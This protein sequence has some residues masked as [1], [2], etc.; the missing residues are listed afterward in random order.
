MKVTVDEAELK[1]L[2]GL[3]W[4]PWEAPSIINSYQFTLGLAVAVNIIFVSLHTVFPPPPISVV[5][6]TFGDMPAS[7]PTVSVTVFEK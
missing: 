5:N 3:A 4:N 6:I 2:V 7:P 1:V